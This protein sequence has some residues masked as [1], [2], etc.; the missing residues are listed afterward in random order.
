M[1]YDY[2]KTC[3]LEVKPVSILQVRIS[4]LSGGS[5]VF[6]VTFT[7]AGADYMSWFDMS[8]VIPAETTYTDLYPGR[9]HLYFSIEGY[10]Q[11]YIN[12]RTIP[13]TI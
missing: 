13:Q 8:R 1:S 12:Y 10:V 9:S 2:N 4:M 11:T 6:T 7:T 3:R 5:K